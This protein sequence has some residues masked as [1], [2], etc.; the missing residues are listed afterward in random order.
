M[1]RQLGKYEILEELG[2]GGFGIVYKAKDLS[3][4]RLAAIK[5]LHPQLTVDTRFVENFKREARNLAK[6]AHPN[7]VSVYEIGELDGRLYIA[8]RYLQGGSL[9]DRLKREGPLALDEAIRILE[10]ASAGL[11]GGHKRGI[12]HRDVKPGNILF[13]EEGQAVIAD[14]GVARAVQISSIGT[15]TETGGTVGTPYYRAPELWRG[16]PAPSPATDVYSLACVLYEMVTGE[17]LFKGKTP[18]Q[19]ITSHLLEDARTLMDASHDA[20]PANIRMVLEKSLAKDPTQRHQSMPAFIQAIKEGSHVETPGQQKEMLPLPHEV[21]FKGE[22]IAETTDNK[23]TQQSGPVKPQAEKSRG[24]PLSTWLLWALIGV[25]G[26]VVLG[27]LIGQ[28]RRPAVQAPIPFATMTA[29]KMDTQ[30]PTK[31]A[32]PVPTKT[33]AKAPT[34]TA[35]KAP[36]NTAAP[37]LGIGSTMIRD[38][39]GMEMVYV[40]AGEFTMG[41][42]EYDDEQPIHQVYLDAY[43]IDKYEVTNGQYA[44]CVAAGECSEPRDSFSYTRSSYYGNSQYEDYPVIYVDWYGAEDYCTWAGGRLPSEAEWEKAAR[45]TAGRTYP[46][47]ND[48][49]TDRL[50]NYISNVGDT[51]EVG[52]YPDGASPYG[53]MDMAGNVW[54]WVADWFGSYSSGLVSNPQGPSTGTYRILR[55]GSWGGS[56][57]GL[58]ASNRYFNYPG[59]AVIIGFRC[60]TSP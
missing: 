44:Q 22:A 34:S 59:Y 32:T 13:D 31:T 26:M 3:L 24:T 40:P 56:E 5:V 30:V 52:S 54:E 18:D 16:S 37:G 27:L 4:D 8:M 7:V 45:G 50:A 36:A 42:N 29:T 14:F 28:S 35:T 17:M 51:T 21:G 58:R 49:P 15:A 38:Q 47:G 48:S 57:I 33:A 53:A 6:I 20:L 43:W 46:W 19:L 39:D 41:S 60:A 11:E 55:G 23:T 10:Q 2:R 9:A 25:L 1:T 12:I